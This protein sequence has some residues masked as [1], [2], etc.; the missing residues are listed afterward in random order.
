MGSR[1]GIQFVV[2]RVATAVFET[3]LAAGVFHQ[4]P[5]QRLR[6]PGREVRAILK[7]PARRPDQ[8]HSSLVHEH[9]GLQ[10]L[11]RRFV[12]HLV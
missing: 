12:W 2:L 7:S 3:R 6:C 1:D 10:G 4:V 5:P 9:G 11:A 8:L